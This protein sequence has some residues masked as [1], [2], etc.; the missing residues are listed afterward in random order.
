MKKEFGI[1]LILFVLFSSCKD[2]DINVFD[3]SADERAS[4]AVASLKKDLVEPT[5]GWRL[6]YTPESGSGSFYVLLT[7]GENNQLNIK[8]DLGANDGEFF[9]QTLTYRIDNSLGLE[10]IFETYSMFAYLFELDQASFGAEYELVFAN[11]TPDGS[12]VFT[13]K[14]DLGANSTL[15]FEKAGDRDDTLFGR[16]LALNLENFERGAR[17]RYNQKN[18]DIYMLMDPVKRTIDF[19]YISTHDNTASGQALDLSTGYLLQQDS[20]ILNTPLQTTFNGSEITIR[21]LQLTTFSEVSANICPTPSTNPSYAG[22]SSGNDPIVL[23]S[24]L[25][26]PE[27]AAFRT[28]AQIYIVDIVNIRDENGNRVDAQIASDIHG[29]SFML[30]YNNYN[31]FNSM[32]FFIDN[33]DGS[34]SIVVRETATTFNGNA[35]GVEFISELESLREPT[36]ANVN[37]IDIYL[38]KLTEGGKMYAYRY[39]EDFFEVH[40]PCSGW[41]FF[42]QAVDL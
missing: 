28:R 35:I 25:F 40:N 27:G 3:K 8:S 26:D 29:A 12:L 14:T 9:E 4:D 15:V 33:D 42:F 7:F 20:L 19:N 1:F 21:S 6:K 16:T 34:I 30:M 39:D 31:D 23:E 11:K 17:I 2:N 5:N 22:V 38:N 24:S 41:T 36:T 13:S 32:G 18:I 10:L 37:N